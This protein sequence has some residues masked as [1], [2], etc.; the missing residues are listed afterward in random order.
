MANNWQ[1]SLGNKVAE[2]SQCTCSNSKTEVSSLGSSHKQENTKP[3][4]LV[5][6]PFR[7]VNTGSRSKANWIQIYRTLSN[8]VP[9]H[10]RNQYPLLVL[11][12]YMIRLAVLMLPVIA[13]MPG[14]RYIVNASDNAVLFLWS[15][16]KL[17]P[18]VLLP[19][20]RQLFLGVRHYSLVQ[21]WITEQQLK[22]ETRVMIDGSLLTVRWGAL[23]S[24]QWLVVP[25]WDAGCIFGV[26]EKLINPI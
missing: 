12:P 6:N 16:W 22:P 3:Q 14:C 19:V 1:Q 8:A 23:I 15:R 10:Q 2:P 25:F 4:D 20:D 17:F 7:P 5:K 26:T 11:M 13:L 9:D 24:P 21:G 18:T